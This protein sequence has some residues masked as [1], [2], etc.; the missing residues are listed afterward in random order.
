MTDNIGVKRCANPKC[1]KKFFRICYEDYA[2]KDGG[3]LYCGYNC[4]QADMRRRGKI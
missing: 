2:W 3:R 4:R 1:K